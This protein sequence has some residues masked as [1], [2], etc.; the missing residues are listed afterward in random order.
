VVVVA[1]EE[2]EVLGVG[3]KKGEEVLVAAPPHTAHPTRSCTSSS[4]R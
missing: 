4:H 2:K 3:W 1:E